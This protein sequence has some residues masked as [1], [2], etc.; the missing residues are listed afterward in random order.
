MCQLPIAI[1]LACCCIDFF[2]IIYARVQF[3]HFHAA[4]HILLICIGKRR[5]HA[6]KNER[7]R[8]HAPLLS[9][10]GT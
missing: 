9:G 2:F 8:T 6:A 5:L 3:I 10:T 7:E 4:L 1:K